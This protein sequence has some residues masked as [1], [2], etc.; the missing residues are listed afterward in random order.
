M[1]PFTV[2]KSIDN[3]TETLAD[4]LS[5]ERRGF[6]LS[7]KNIGN[8]NIVKENIDLL[9]VL[10]SKYSRHS[11][12]VI[13]VD[14]QMFERK[15]KIFIIFLELHCTQCPCFCNGYLRGIERNLFSTLISLQYTMFMTETTDSS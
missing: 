8:E 10:S 7:T 15:K 6:T 12:V 13:R 2:V 9:S 3:L 1:G 4:M 11:S 5:A 14:G